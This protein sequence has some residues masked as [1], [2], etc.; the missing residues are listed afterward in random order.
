MVGRMQTRG[1]QE[2]G[3]AR[4]GF[5]LIELLV[6]VAIIAILAGLL[7]P[8]LAGGK[9]RARRA[10]CKSNM[11][12]F[13]LAVHMYAQDNENELPSGLSENSEP[14]DEHIPMVSGITR[15]NLTLYSG[16]RRMIECP[17]LGSPFNQED[18]WYYPDYGYVIGY[19]Y[20][21]G[22]LE[23]P[24]PDYGIFSGFI[25]PQSLSDLPDLALV[26]DINDWS[27]GFG[28]TFAPH[29]ANGPISKAAD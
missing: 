18:G 13:I 5:T 27:P 6:V 17:N 26:T 11:R 2:R 14:A 16:N 9:E 15:S 21:G 29:S 20:L 4:T 7:L 25:S 22:H 10:T 24:W 19:N 3:Q 12:Q 8:A 1:C 23:T 28:K